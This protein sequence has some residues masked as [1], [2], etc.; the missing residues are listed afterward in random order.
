MIE[1]YLG[2]STDYIV[3]GLAAVILILLI[4]MIVA[5]VKISKLKKKYTSF[6]RGKNGKSLE[7]TLIKKLNEIEE[8][9]EANASNERKI[10]TMQKKLSF[11][12]TKYGLVKYDALEELGGKLSYT[13]C[14]LNESNDG[15]IINVVHSREGC[16]NYTKEVIDGNSIVT[17]SGEEEEALEKALSSNK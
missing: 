4:L 2:I 9:T 17:L 12:F 13:L 8:L 16:Y 15:Y 1:Q 10:E 11:A 7:E 5:L 3:I 14:M 6:M